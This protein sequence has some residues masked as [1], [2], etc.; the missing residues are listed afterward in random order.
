MCLKWQ[1]L[2]KVPPNT[3]I[4]FLNTKVE[5]PA[6]IHKQIVAVYGD[7]MNCQNVMKWCPEYSEGR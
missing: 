5:H 4:Q 2:F 1:H 6:E 3:I 7:V